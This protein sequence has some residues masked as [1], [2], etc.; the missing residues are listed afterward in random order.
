MTPEQ[1]VLETVEFYRK[2][3]RSLVGGPGTS[4]LYNGKDGAVCAYARLVKPELRHHLAEFRDIFDC[5]V[6]P[7]KDN[8]IDG[9]FV[10][11]DDDEYFYAF[12]QAI[13]DHSFFSI[14][15]KEQLEEAKVRYCRY[16]EKHW[17]ML[18]KALT[19]S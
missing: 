13:H 6:P 7:T 2:N 5:G 11:D 8:L 16:A 1:I 4:C 17:D 14:E 12:L 9:Y 15:D 10:H 3:P 19:L 18:E